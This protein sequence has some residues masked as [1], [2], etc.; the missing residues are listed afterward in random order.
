MDSKFWVGVSCE[1]V[2]AEPYGVSI[3]QLLKFYEDK[4]IGKES[5]V[6]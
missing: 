3:N 1:A 5:L 6:P 2:D 4:F